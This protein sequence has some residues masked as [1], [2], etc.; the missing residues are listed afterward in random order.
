MR[1][2]SSQCGSRGGAGSGG[3]FQSVRD[4][5]AR[6]DGSSDD[7]G[8]IQEA[9]DECGQAGGGTVVLPAG[10]YLTGT[11]HLRDRVT[12]QLEAGATIR[13]STDREAYDVPNLICAE[14]VE[15][16]AIVGRGRIDGQ[17]EAFW[18]REGDR[19]RPGEWRP[20][21]LVHFERCRNVLMR[22]VTVTNA[23]AWTVHTLRCDR[24]TIS[25]VTILNDMQGPNTDGI[26]PNCSTN[27]HISDCH[28]AAGDDCIVVKATEPYPCENITV[29]NCTLE[30]TCAA[31]KLGT[32]THGDIRHCT[33]SN[34]TIR[35]TRVGIALYMKDGGTME[36]IT[37][38]DISMEMK[39]RSSRM[40][41]WPILMDL[42]RRNPDSKV[43]TVRDVTIRNVQVITKGR[44]IV[45][46]MRDRP[47]ERLTVDGL[48]LKIRGATEDL[49]RVGKPRGG[50]TSW[51]DPEA[52][53]HVGEP[54]HMV[55]ANIDGLRLRN[56]EI[57][58]E[59][60]S[61]GV[62]RSAIYGNALTDVQIAGFRG[63]QSVP[64]GSLPAVHLVD[65]R[66]VML[67]GCRPPIDTGTFLQLDGAA[68]RSV[69]L[70]GNDL[71][72]SRHAVRVGDGVDDVAVE[73]Q[74][75]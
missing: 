40:P 60:G 41:D 23:P 37:F 1:S 75:T 13:G 58:A 52:G 15:D 70:V 56:V 46:G 12:L 45:Q 69:R 34:C 30:T 29:S 73:T 6:G 8:P 24:V 36:G 19:W 71:S 4:H 42:E 27:V 51:T 59:S 9:I 74:L 14:G 32:E 61:E 64:G 25:G 43:G 31:L 3:P 33:F 55:F 50:R 26:D 7:R 22:D 53:T 62:E 68:T 44:C 65:C 2:P 66:E 54:A 67:S 57:V 38:S 21:R 28:I 39:G 16:V 49:E 17:G 5:G 35:N 10:D 18:V 72:R 47:I 48:T 11:L 20:S 63:R